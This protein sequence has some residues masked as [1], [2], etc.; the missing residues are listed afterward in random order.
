MRFLLDLL[1]ALAAGFGADYVLARL[2]MT[3]PLKVVIAV[4]IGIVV[5]L[6]NP[7]ALILNS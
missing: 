5:F 6:A 7:A 1:I 2:K 3:D 4:I